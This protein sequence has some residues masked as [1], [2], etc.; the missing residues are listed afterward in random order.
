MGIAG[1]KS[2]KHFLHYHRTDEN[3]LWLY[4]PNQETFKCYSIFKDEHPFFFGGLETISVPEM[5]AVFTVGGLWADNTT[6]HKLLEE[7]QLSN[8]GKGGYSSSFT[9]VFDV[10]LGYLRSRETSL[11][12]TIMNPRGQI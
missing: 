10:F 2:D 11:E 8:P 12:R 7:R 9:D 5:G 4:T 3:K 1:S 6:I